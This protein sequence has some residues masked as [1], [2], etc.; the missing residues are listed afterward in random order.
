MHHKAIGIAGMVLIIGSTTYMLLGRHLDELDPSSMSP[1][2]LSGI[3]FLGGAII[4]KSGFDVRLRLPLRSGSPGALGL[5]I[6]TSLLV[7]GD[8]GRAGHSC[9][10]VR[11]R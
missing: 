11:R 8:N 5:A 4:F 3:S 10:D 6:A 1:G 9:G 7:A 2:F